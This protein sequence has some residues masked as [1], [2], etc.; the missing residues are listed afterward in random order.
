MVGHHGEGLACRALLEGLRDRGTVA[1]VVEA[2]VH[3][4]VQHRE[5][6]HLGDGRGVVEEA[7]A[8][9]VGAHHAGVDVRIVVRTDRLIEGIGER[10]E[11]STPVEFSI[12]MMPITSASSASRAATN[13]AV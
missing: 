8:D 2:G 1:V 5:V 13:F 12:S 7:H 10:R 4:G 11:G 6:A 9:R 3:R